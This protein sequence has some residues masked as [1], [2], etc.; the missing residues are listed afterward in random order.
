MLLKEISVGAFFKLQATTA[1]T[2]SVALIGSSETDF[3]VF[4][5]GI[6]VAGTSD[7]ADAGSDCGMTA[8]VGICTTGTTFIDSGSCTSCVTEVTDF[9]TLPAEVRVATGLFEALG[10]ASVVWYMWCLSRLDEKKRRSMELAVSCLRY[11]RSL[12]RFIMF[13]NVSVGPISMTFSV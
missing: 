10:E 11:L 1:L 8:A 7:T 5:I 12:V 2:T 13:V 9:W 4:I 6:A 3:F